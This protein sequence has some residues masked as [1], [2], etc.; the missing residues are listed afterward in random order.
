MTDMDTSEF[1]EWAPDYDESV[2]KS[3]EKNEYPF[4]GYSKVVRYILNSIRKSSRSGKIL[5]VGIGTGS[6]SYELYK[7]GYEISG[8]DFSSSMMEI[9]RKKMPLAHLYSCDISCGLPDIINSEKYDAVI[10]DYAIHHLTDEQQVR[11]IDQIM[12][13]VKNAGALYIGDVCFRS[14]RDMERARKSA[15]ESWDESENYI[16]CDE[17]PINYT[18]KYTR[19]SFCSGVVTVYP[20]QA[21]RISYVYILRCNDGTFYTGWTNDPEKRL[22]AHNTGRGAN[23]TKTRAPSVIVYTESFNSR[24]EAMAREYEIK[25]LSRKEKEALIDDKR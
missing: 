11:L 19:E 22:K 13:H 2:R 1:D 17:L 10:C 21:D 25:H 4:S 16:V 8:L 24:E 23:Y 9:S 5:D 20:K 3:E 14:L 6:V 18:K 15:G 12:T 7:K